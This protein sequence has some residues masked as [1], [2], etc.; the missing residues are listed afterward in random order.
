[1]RHACIASVLPR[2]TCPCIP[3]VIPTPHPFFARE[4]LEAGVNLPTIQRYL[5]DAQIQTTMIHLFDFSR[6][7]RAH[8]TNVG[9]AD[10]CTCI[11]ALMAD[12][13]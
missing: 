9:Q 1:M 5:G 13:K 3:C 8:L 4:K 11:Q 2:K 6:S 10:A 12:L 7:A